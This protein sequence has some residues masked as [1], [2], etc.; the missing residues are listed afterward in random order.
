MKFAPNCS[1]YDGIMQ[2]FPPPPDKRVTATNWD[3]PPFNQW[4][5]QN[6]R[7]I[8][9]T[10]L[11]SKGTGSASAFETR[12]EDLGAL[13]YERANGTAST[14][15]EMLL[16]T[17]T[18]GFLVLHKGKIVAEQYFNTMEPSTLHLAQSVSKSFVGTVAGILI[19]RG[20]IDPTKTVSSY[21]PELENCGYSDATVAHVLNMRSGIRFSE[22]YTDLESEI[23][24]VD[25][26]SGWKPRRHDD[27]PESMYELMPRL[28]QEREHGGYFQYRSIETDVLGWV[29]EK[30]TGKSLSSLLSDELWSKMGMEYDALITVD[31][32]GACLADGG[33]CASLRD[34]ARFGQMYLNDGYFNGQQIVPAAWTHACRAGDRAAFEPLYADRFPTFPNA[35]YT[36]QWWAFDPS[37]PI[38][39]AVGVFGQLIHIDQ[40]NEL[41]VAKLSH[42]PDF[43]NDK[44]RLNTFAAIE[45]ISQA[46]AG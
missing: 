4:G 45:A 33:L 11:I 39:C 8:L 17:Y 18:D 21:I 34:Y 27:D 3:Y 20:E 9:P 6:I 31:R 22:E 24:L 16:E 7:R 43:L 29:C 26:A 35:C 46:L 15:A 19:H 42:W 12:A 1:A 28:E 44:F 14:V 41:V 37:V 10:A 36:N 23:A 40:R 25:I 2:G 30:V 13:A 32:Q 5:F 38:Y